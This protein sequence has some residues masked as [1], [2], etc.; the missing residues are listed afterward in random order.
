MKLA[1]DIRDRFIRRG[2]TIGALACLAL[3]VT[4]LIRGDEA[5]LFWNAWYFCTLVVAGVVFVATR[6]RVAWALIAA[7]APIAH[8]LAADGDSAILSYFWIF[9]FPIICFFVLGLRRGMAVAGLVWASA[10]GIILYRAE[11]LGLSQTAPDVVASLAVVTLLGWAYETLRDR[12]ERELRVSLVTD[13]LTGIS[14]RRFFNEALAR[15]IERAARYERPMSLLLFDLDDFKGVNDDH[16]HPAGDDVLKRVAEVVA[17][18]LRTSDLFA[19]LGGDEFAIIAPETPA[20][21]G[22]TMEAVNLAERIRLAVASTSFDTGDKLTLSIGVTEYVG[23]DD[24]A[25]IVQ[26]ADD[27]LYLAKERGRDQVCTKAGTPTPDDEQP[28]YLSR[29]V[30][31]ATAE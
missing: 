11:S 23:G 26:R 6:S 13:E 9:P 19:R 5:G 8:L 20:R 22:G 25:S 16:G 15:E 3:T 10:A 28:S 17:A 2:S 14:N 21:G 18:E 31:V 24:T 29:R 30:E 27:A 4:D 12:H 1:D 7:Q